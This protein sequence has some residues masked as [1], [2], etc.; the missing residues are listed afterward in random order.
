MERTGN[1]A[2][3]R[4]IEDFLLEQM[5]DWTTDDSTIAALSDGELAHGMCD[6]VSAQFKEFAE[7]RGF[8]AYVT[9]TDLD[10]LGYEIKCAA[11]GEVL[12]ANGDIVLG[13]YEEHTIVTI[14]VDDADYHYGREFYIDF[15]AAQYG[16]TEHPKVTT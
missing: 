7:A 9:H 8:K 1:K 11:K 13:H 14:V 12:N 4:L 15:T 3:D 5:G 6:M 16:Y 2:V 10:E